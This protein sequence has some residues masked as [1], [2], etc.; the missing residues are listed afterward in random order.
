MSSEKPSGN[1]LSGNKLSGSFLCPSDSKQFRKTYHICLSSKKE[2]MF[3]S[4]E[5]YNRAFN[6]YA[7]ALHKTDSIGLADS[8]M[9]NHLH[10]IV[11]T[12]CP[13]ILMYAFRNSY[14]KY[15]NRKYQRH[16]RLGDIKHFCIE[17]KG[18]YH[19][20][21]AISYTLRNALHHGIA[22][23]PFGYKHSSINSVFKDALGKT[24]TLKILPKK[25]YYKHLGQHTKFPEHFIMSE[26]GLFLREC[27]Y[28]IQLVENLFA[29]PRAFNYYMTRKTNEEWLKEQEKDNNNIPPITLQ[30]IEHWAFKGEHDISNTLTGDTLRTFLQHEHGRNDYNRITDIELCSIIDRHIKEY[31]KSSSST[32]TTVYTIPLEEKHSLAKLLQQKYYIK[33]EQLQRCLCFNVKK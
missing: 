20:L 7:L 32:N 19:I 2:V 8:F 25:S 10:L 13:E 18:L 17:L 6:Y 1:K 31:S 16:G 21:A 29:T 30:D 14:A 3:R 5:D 27:V 22:A 15:F 24:H 26:E 33:P 9:S 12:S 11:Q 28:D 4:H 23:T